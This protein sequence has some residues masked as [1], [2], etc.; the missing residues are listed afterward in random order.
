MGISDRRERRLLILLAFVSFVVMATEVVPVGVASVFTEQQRVGSGGTGLLVITYALGVAAGGPL[1]TLTVVR[2]D[3]RLLLTT[4]IGAFAI[5][6]AMTAAAPTMPLILTARSLSGLIAGATFAAVTAFGVGAASGTA[7]GGR[8]FD[9][10]PRWGLI[11]ASATTGL[12]LLALAIA[13]S[14]PPMVVGC[15][16]FGLGAFAAIPILQG[17]VLHH[18]PDAPLIAAAVNVSAFNL[19]NAIGAGAGAVGI[20]AFGAAG[21][22]Y[23]GGFETLGVGAALSV[24]AVRSRPRR[25]R[26]GS[27]SS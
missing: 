22:A 24:I 5:S 10:S 17:G 14:T 18:A 4:L 7:L 3:Q 16:F 21:P 6:Q 27:V 26:V 12:S 13:G 23:I 15:F 11:V 1:L 19:A 20:A 2:V 9:R 8:A 25:R